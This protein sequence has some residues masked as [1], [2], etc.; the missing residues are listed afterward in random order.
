MQ[1][2]LVVSSSKGNLYAIASG[3]FNV[4]LLF[5]SNTLSRNSS[6][7]LFRQVLPVSR[8]DDLV[9]NDRSMLTIQSTRGCHTSSPP[10]SK[11]TE[12][13]ETVHLDREVEKCPSGHFVQPQSGHDRLTDRRP[14]RTTLTVRGSQNA[15]RGALRYDTVIFN[16]DREYM[17]G[18]P[19][20]D[21]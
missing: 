2:S 6:H 20:M 15:Q 16:P 4:S 3:Y 14:W 18:N 11:W 1:R 5:Y 19:T 13:S 17:T 9:K 7:G 12:T 21:G 8:E 10:M